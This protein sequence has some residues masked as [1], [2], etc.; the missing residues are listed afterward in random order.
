MQIERVQV[1]KNHLVFHHV[2]QSEE[3]SGLN[4]VQCGFESHHGDIKLLSGSFFV[5]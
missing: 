3:A 1:P 4:P 5:L 2:A